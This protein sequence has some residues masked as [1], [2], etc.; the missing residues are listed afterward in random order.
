[1]NKLDQ[2]SNITQLDT[3]GQFNTIKDWPQMISQG[4]QL[5]TQLK[6]PTTVEIGK[7]TLNYSKKF[8]NLIVCGMGGSAISGEYMQNLISTSQFKLH[9]SIIRGYQLP[10]YVNNNSL[11]IIITYSGNT[12]ETLICLY[13]AIERNIPI[14]I[15]SSG[16]TAITIAKKYNIPFLQLSS[17]YQPRA[18]FPLLFSTLAGVINNILPISNDSE[19][20][21]NQT[22][23]LL[24]KES[25]NLEPKS[26]NQ[27]NLAKKI[28]NKLL[29][30]KDKVP[31]FLTAHSALGMR[32]KGQ[33]NE[34]ANL[35]AFYD[36][37]PELMQNSVQGWKD[38]KS[39]QFYF[40][41]I[42]L[43]S[44]SNEMIDK[45]KYSL[46]IAHP[47]EKIL[48][49]LIEIEG[50]SFLAEL[51]F[52]TYLMDY[53]SLYLAILQNIDPSEM[54]MI[55]NMKKTFD[56]KLK[57]EFDVEKALLSLE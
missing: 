49:E 13:K 5:G 48:F 27:N 9:F 54:I 31:M 32:M 44:D 7:Y 1:M 3:Q 43:G 28:A 41:L 56:S 15:I 21:F 30:N 19:A 57:I 36:I 23:Q 20:A 10:S 33:F 50:P 53:I 22:I 42:K 37:F 11:A 55:T 2:I 16:G 18:A 4:F 24:K 40:I 25:N 35:V 6:L 34:N 45:I 38:K 47:D 12:R 39:L 26:P 17:S 29:Q 51:L 52:A 46:N 8:L 14:I